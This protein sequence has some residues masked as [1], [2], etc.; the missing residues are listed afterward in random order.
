M[1]VVGIT[2]HSGLTEPTLVLVRQA[3]DAELSQY[4]GADLTG[5]TCLARGADQLF[6]DA[7]LALGGALHVVPAAD[8]FDNITDPDARRR[9]AEYLRQAAAVDQMQFQT[10]GRDAIVG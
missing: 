8:Y 6:A 2:G 5:M 10:A 1:T 3:L 9:C 4:E 7:I